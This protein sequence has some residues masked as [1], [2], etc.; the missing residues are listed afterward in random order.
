MAYIPGFA[1]SWRLLRWCGVCEGRSG[2]DGR[3]SASQQGEA[4][5]VRGQGGAGDAER[6]TCQCLAVYH[7]ADASVVG[8]PT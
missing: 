1:S 3:C 7:G 2:E 5:V 6:Y 4:R 8:T